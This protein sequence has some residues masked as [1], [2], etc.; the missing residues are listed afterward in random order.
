MEIFYTKEH[1]WVK[2]EGGI[3]A[4]GI[5]NYAVKQLGDIT[6]VE[7]PAVG[8]EV[9][10]HGVLCTVESV[11]AASD[12][13]APLSGRVAEVNKELENSPKIINSSPEGLGWIARI[14]ISDAGETG[15]LMGEEKYGE[16]LKTLR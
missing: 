10:Q 12:V 13:Y 14:E 3:G 16:Y 11:K 7:L 1:E 6:S 2:V 5:S 4:V 8:T 9:K 15:N